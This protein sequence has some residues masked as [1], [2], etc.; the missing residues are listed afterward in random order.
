[1]K[2]ENWKLEILIKPQRGVNPRPVKANYNFTVY[3][4]DR[5][6]ELMS[7]VYQLLPPGDV[8]GNIIFFVGDVVL[9]E[10][11]FGHL[12]I[13]TAWRGINLHRT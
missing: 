8:S 13:G 12:A 10:I 7:P 2:I 9:F 3:I 5:H 11:F 6:S 1:M 4:N